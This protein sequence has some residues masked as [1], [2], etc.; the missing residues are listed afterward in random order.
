MILLDTTSK[1]TNFTGLKKFVDE[2]KVTQDSTHG[3]CV[4]LIKWLKK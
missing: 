1:K 4:T 3:N 2:V